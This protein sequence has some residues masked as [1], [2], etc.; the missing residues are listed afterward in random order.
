MADPTTPTTETTKPT[1]GAGPAPQPLPARRPPE[2]SVLSGAEKFADGT[3]HVGAAIMV[4]SDGNPSTLMI[5][6]VTKIPTGAPVYITKPIRI[7]GKN[8]QA[9]LKEKEIQ[10]PP[11]IGGT[12]AIPAKDSQKAVPAKPG[13]IENT[14]ISCE[15]FYFTTNGP[16]LMMFQVMVQDGLIASLTGDDA[17]GKLFDVQ[18]ASVRIIRCPKTSYSVLQDYVAELTA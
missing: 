1:D 5:P 16:L 13:L 4:T 15:A 8:L 11:A 12:P 17:L 14:K 6:D 18:G 3:V 2:S 7:D 10:L 9:F